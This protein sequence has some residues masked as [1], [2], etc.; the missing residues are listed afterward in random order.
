MLLCPEIQQHLN[1]GHGFRTFKVTRMAP[2]TILLDDHVH[3][4]VRSA[5]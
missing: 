4:W 1:H 3:G 2:R 5:V